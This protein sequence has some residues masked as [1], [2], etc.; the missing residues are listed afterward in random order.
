MISS[1]QWLSA[2]FTACRT[3]KVHRSGRLNRSLKVE[4][5]EARDNPAVLAP[6]T[7]TTVGAGRGT[8]QLTMIYDMNANNRYDAGD[9]T[10]MG[11][12]AMIGRNHVLTAGHNIYDNDPRTPTVGFPKW[13]IATPGRAGNVAP[14]GQALATGMTVPS[15]WAQGNNTADI[16]IIRLNANL[17]DRTGSFSYWAAPNNVIAGSTLNIRHY[18][19]DSRSGFNGTQ[20]YF[21]S[22]RAAALTNDVIG[23]RHDVMA[24]FGGSSGSPVFVPQVNVGGKLY[25]NVIVGVHVRGALGQQGYLNQSTRITATY[26]TMVTNALRYDGVTGNLGTQRTQLA[27]VGASQNFAAAE[28]TQSAVGTE[29]LGSLLAHDPAELLLQPDRGVKAVP[30]STLATSVAVK[31]IPVSTVDSLPTRFA[32]V[33]NEVSVQALTSHAAATQPVDDFFAGLGEGADELD[34]IAGKLAMAV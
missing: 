33:V 11:T 34:T 20:Q 18:P 27:S 6:V 26:Q 3:K 5:L 22:G 23:Y 4:T 2:R 9:S 30:L 16:G 17:G 32:T 7:N 15:A 10:G 29:S 25:N 28:M 14:F 1:L 13:V 8:V 12:G 19:A 21:S 24:T 31:A